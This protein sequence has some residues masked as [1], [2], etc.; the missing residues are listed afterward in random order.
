[1][2]EV[3]MTQTTGKA[4]TSTMSRMRSVVAEV[5]SVYLV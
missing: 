1:L 2:S 3:K 5:L 4:H